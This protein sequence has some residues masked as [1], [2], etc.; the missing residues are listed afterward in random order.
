MH[1]EINRF[2]EGVINIPPSKSVAHRAVIC[3]GLARGE[4]RIH[5]VSD[6]MDILATVNCMKG[7][8]VSSM[9]NK[10]LLEVYGRSHFAKSTMLD[11]GESGSTLRFLIPVA[12][13]LSNEMYFTGQG[14]LMERPLT[15]YIEALGQKGVRLSLKGN[16]L[17]LNGSL[18]AGE[19][20]L[21]GDV[22]S[23]FVSGLLFALPLLKEDSRINITTPL[24]SAS[25]VDLTI[26]V[27]KHFG[28]DIVNE[29]YKH[30]YIR[31]GQDYNPQDFTVEAD[32]SQAA[33]FLVASALGCEC[34]CR[35]LSENSL[36]GDKRILEILRECGAEIITT[37]QGGI[38][39]KADRLK[40]TTVDVSDIPDLVPVLAVLF[41]FCEGTSYITNADRLRYKESDRLHSITTELNALGANIC[42]NNDSLTITGVKSLKGGKVKSWGDHRIAMALAVAAI[43]SENPVLLEQSE[44]VSKS[45]PNFWEDFE[46]KSINN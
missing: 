20:E 25:Y 30:F 24:Q 26:S 40:S 12:A 28:I 27:M 1:R 19:F 31:G 36:Q 23:Q 3:A 35:G 4:S 39:V 42:E 9:F 38:I 37:D 17:S 46:K 43:K 45:Y 15:P 22:S 13:V 18:Q 2:P 29:G 32:Y 34:E 11:C 44:S 14:R 8:G 6:S 5:N 33:F 16:V 41:S 10:N 21:T 7:L